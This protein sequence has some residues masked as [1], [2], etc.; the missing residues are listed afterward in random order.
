VGVGN[1][2]AGQTATGYPADAKEV[3]LVP[4]K[5][6]GLSRAELKTSG[7]GGNDGGDEETVIQIEGGS[8]HTLFL[9]SQGRVF[10][11][12]RGIDGQ[13]G[14]LPSHLFIS[15][16][17]H[18]F[19]GI[20]FTDT[21]V[22]LPTLVTFP[23]STSIDPVKH[24]AVGEHNNLVVTRD[25]AVYV[26]GSGS[27]GGLGLGMDVRRVEV[28]IVLV[29]RAGGTVEAISVACAGSHCLGLFRR[30]A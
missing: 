14:L 27:V 19:D 21:F 1:E 6:V 24:I 12:G 16:R 23:T 28:P 18:T 20:S 2:R 9:T 29:R 25:G 3:I 8:D 10:S 13:L 17:N 7:N 4:Q 5:V 30:R 26:W 15:R 11:Y 22:A